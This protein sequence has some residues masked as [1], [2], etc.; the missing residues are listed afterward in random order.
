MNKIIRSVI[1]SFIGLF[2]RKL[3]SDLSPF[4]R[5]RHRSDFKL[6]NFYISS[7]FSVVD[8]ALRTLRKRGYR[9]LSNTQNYSGFFRATS[10][11]IVKEPRLSVGS[12]VPLTLYLR[13]C[14]F[15]TSQH[16]RVIS[17]AISNGWNFAF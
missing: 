2:F 7:A 1:I 4:R 16:A 11:G 9:G 6:S 5:A 12:R 13:Y 3:E 17:V 10:L 8:N 15:L 14:P